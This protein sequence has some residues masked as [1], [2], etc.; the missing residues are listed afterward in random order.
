VTGREDRTV[1][2]VDPDD[3]TAAIFEER[4]GF[5]VVAAGSIESARDAADFRDVDCVV[6]EYELADGTAFDLFEVVRESAP[7]AGCVLFTAAGHTEIDPGA[8][9]NAVAEYLPKGGRNAETR[10]VETVEMIVDDRTQVGFPLPPDENERL[11]ALS[12]YDVRDYDAMAAFDR[13][14]TLVA[15]HFDVS[16]A[17]IGLIG[18]VE[19][20]FVACHGADWTTL[21]R[22]D[23]ICTY[24]I[25]D[26]EV[27]VVEDVREDPRFRYNE[28]PER[29]DVRSYAG[30]NITTPGGEVVG[31]L[32]LIDDEPRSYTVQE[33]GDLQ[34][35]A[36]EVAEQFELRRRLGEVEAS[37]GAAA[38]GGR[39]PGWTVRGAPDG[40]D[41]TGGVGADR[42][43]GDGPDSPPEGGGDC[44]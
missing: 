18:E 36:D 28:T 41:R 42:Q 30:A 37:D 23:S 21:A 10:L 27:T 15:S 11:E 9:R 44:V 7:N 26:E 19:E 8:V 13:L 38:D 1:L 14:S 4:P 5:T 29:Q 39:R 31:E 20:R 40:T 33:Q 24:A 3:A 43:A 16:I 2:C 32:C 17:F 6:A 12:A 35:F 22:E 34:L 25:L